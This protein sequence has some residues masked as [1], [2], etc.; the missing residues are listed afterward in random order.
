MN[1]LNRRGLRVEFAQTPEDIR[2]CQKLRYQVFARELGAAIGDPRLETDS[3]AFDPY[4]RHL[5]VREHASDAIV[6]CTRILTSETS[7]ACGGFYSQQEFD[8]SP[9]LALPGRVMEVGRTCVHADYR[10]GP[11]IAL[12]LAGLATFMHEN[13]CDYLIGCG[14]VPLSADRECALQT[15]A[16]LIAIYGS[17][18]HL[19]VKPRNPLPVPYADESVCAGAD[20]AAP[21]LLR[22]YMRLGAY[23]CGAPCF[24]ADFNVADVFVL[25]LRSRYDG[26]YLERLLGRSLKQRVA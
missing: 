4:C 7:A 20:G 26:R 18:P 25:L 5:V 17:P 16:H 3:D 11:A 6:A 2:E 24:D 9:I 23:V 14:S 22:A 15:V 19:R 10:R 1:G 8:L 13:R 12:L 21:A